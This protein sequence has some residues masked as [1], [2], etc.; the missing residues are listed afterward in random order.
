M[1]TG[2]RIRHYRKKLGWKLKD[3]AE[4]SGVDVGTI[5]A[6]ESRDSSRSEFFQ[7]IAQ[8][9]G[10]TVEQL[11]DVSQDYPVVDT[12]KQRDQW[13][14]SPIIQPSTAQESFLTFVWP[15]KD[16]LPGHWALLDEAEKANFENLILSCVKNRGDPKKNSMPANLL[17]ASK[18]T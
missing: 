4:A 12:R 3:L 1:A 2:I 14:S 17:T 18:A 7:K 6:L 9:Y 8:A 16:V 5:S 15:F 13:G 10:L 11:N